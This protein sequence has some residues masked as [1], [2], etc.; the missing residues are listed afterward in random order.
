MLPSATAATITKVQAVSA[1]MPLILGLSWIR[2][3]AG[4]NIISLI[5][6]ARA[7]YARVRGFRHDE[8]FNA[9]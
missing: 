2:D 5:G 1:V 8:N 4:V 7:P 6:R 3:M 9:C